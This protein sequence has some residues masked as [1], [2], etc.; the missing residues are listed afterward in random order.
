MIPVINREVIE[1]HKEK[2]PIEMTNEKRSTFLADALPL[3]VPETR[4]IAWTGQNIQIMSS[5]KQCGQI[6][7]LC[8]LEFKGTTTTKVIMRPNSYVVRCRSLKRDDGYLYLLL[9]YP[10]Q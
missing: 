2:V 5:A 6:H 3:S 9:K 1:L 7:F 4:E 10:R 8:L